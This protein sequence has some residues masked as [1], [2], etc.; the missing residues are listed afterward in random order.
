[1]SPTHFQRDC[2]SSGVALAGRPTQDHA[3]GAGRCAAGG[4][5]SPAPG[6]RDFAVSNPRAAEFFAGM[7]LMRAGLNRCSIDT[8]FANDVDETKASIYRDNWGDRELVVGD[9]RDLAGRDVPS[10]DLATA[11]SPCVD[12]S[13]AGRR[14]GL[15]GNRSG[16][17]FDFCRILGEMGDRAPPTIMIENVPGLLTVNGGR[18]YR[19]VTHELRNLGYGTDC[20]CVDAAAFIPQSRRR[21]FIIGS[22]DGTP[23]LPPPPESRTAMRLSDVANDDDKWWSPERLEAFLASLSPRQAERVADYQSRT[24]VGHFGAFRRTRNGRAVWEVRADEIAGAL[25]TTRGG[26][27]KQAV[28]RAGRGEL[29]V[30]WMN[31][32]EYARLQGA[33]D[34]LFGSV[35][36]HKAMFALGDGVCVPVIE[37]VGRHCL[38]PLI[39]K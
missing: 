12:V 26:S 3:D 37:W 35:S 33:G 31:A 8:V 32:R 18:D 13:L 17:L 7:G 2:T 10:V 29:A 14:L 1:M 4:E 28:L 21:V 34:M 16:V 6:P 27:A 20:V 36:P 15:N 11:S 23:L 39:S 30:R 22:R 9:I 5:A 24:S 38:L 25:R 19:Q